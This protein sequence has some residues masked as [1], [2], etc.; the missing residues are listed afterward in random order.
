VLAVAGGAAG[1]LLAYWATQLL[2]S[3]LTGLV[4]V[5]VTFDPMP[6][7]RVLAATLGFSALATVTFGLWPA[8]RLARTDTVSGLKTEAGE[9]RGRVGRRFGSGNVLVVAQI[10]LSLALLVASGL[11][12]RGALAGARADAG[13]AMDRTVLVR[14]DP[15]LAGY[16]EVRG[17][18]VYRRVLERLRSAPGVEAVAAA[19]LVP[20]GEMTSTSDVQR[21]GPPLRSNDPAARGRLVEA[22]HYV[23]GADYFRALGIRV[24]RGRDFSPTE[25]QQ[26]GGIVPVIIDEPLAR[27]L[28]G[29]DDPIGRRIRLALTARS[30]GDE[31]PFEVVGLVAATRHDLFAQEAEPHLYVPFGA[32]YTPGMNIHV[33]AAR[34]VEPAALVETVRR[35]IRDTD[36]RL[37]V[38][39][40]T[41]LASF[42]DASIPLWM[43]RTAAALFS[44]FGLS[45]VFVAVV[46]LYGVKSYVVS[47]RVREFGVRMALGAS[48][49][50][51]LKMVF[52]EGA[53]VA[54]AGLVLGLASGAGLGLLVGSLLYQVSPLDPPTFVVA[55]AVLLTAALFASWA[56][57]RRAGRVQPMAALRQER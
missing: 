12:I 41:T 36:P 8:W 3:T 29:A 52:R 53:I 38:F 47:R 45:A 14:L 34:G 44:V 50:D 30:T 21:D 42:R 4:P 26:A 2:L 11:F 1:L 17:R 23:I 54:A 43:L 10:A 56:P 6:D 18:D 19:S 24:L 39:G 40:V 37:P 15:S 9:L 46:G 16:D 55:S 31:A 48:A 20:F 13:F 57:A 25:E 27:R 49:G 35:E 22:H 7:V 5:V 51:I 33:R 32:D 28:F